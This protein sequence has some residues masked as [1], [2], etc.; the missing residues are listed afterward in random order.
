VSTTVERAFA[1]YGSHEV[2]RAWKE[3]PGL[4]GYLSTVNHKRLGMRYIY[5]AFVFFF[6]AGIM[7]LVMRTQ[8]AQ[9]NETLLTPQQYDELFTMH[10]TTMIFLFNTPVLAGFGIYLVPLMIGARDMAFPRLNAFGYYVFLLS[11]LF[12]YAGFLI[13]H[14]PDGG[15]FAYVPLTGPAYSPGYAID[16]WGLGIAFT[17]IST[18]TGAIN[19][20]VTIYKLRAPGMSLNRM[21]LFVWSMLVFSFMV[22]FSFP[23]I[24]LASSLLELDRIFGTQFFNPLAQGSVLLYQ[25]LFWFWGH[26]EVYILLIPA[27]GMVS[28]IIATF[29][30]RPIAG[31]LWIVH[32]LIAIGFISF[33]VW[34]HHMFATGIPILALSFFSA[35]SLLVVIPSGIQF[36]AWIAT[37][38]SGRVK[39]DTPLLFMLGFLLVFLAG[40]ITG[41]M[42]AILP[43]D[44]QVT[45]SY[46]VVAHFH[47]VLN[48]AVVFPIFGAIYYWAPKMTGRM[49][50]ERL[51]KWSF[52]T[53]F[54]SFN[55]AFFPMHI[56]GLL[57]MPRRVSTYLPGLGWDNLNLIET[58]GGFAF[59]IGAG[60][61]LF[62]FFWS[63]RHGAVA[64]PNPWDADSLEW[65]VP[66]PPPEYNFA[67]T[68]IVA[69][70]HPLWDE[71]PL[72]VSSSVDGDATRALAIEGAANRNMAETTVFDAQPEG[73]WPVPPD[74]YLPFF[75][76]FAL[77]IF[78]LGLLMRA[79]LVGWTGVA[80]AVFCLLRWMWR[81][82]EELR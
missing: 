26:P 28:M 65:S 67:T 17:G 23:S 40:G 1:E 78:F 49:L 13:G 12:M 42:V 62:N 69:S 74:T 2:E 35:V 55:V 19:F 8:L 57:G 31:Y 56:V 6:A 29:A 20:I 9:P 77:A 34:S 14:A 30:R 59:G 66:S 54:I 47:Y 4:A 51:G 37:L 79:Q 7:A 52:W 80:I 72:T 81:T 82:D 63:R 3:K 33:G 39:F 58:I 68:P 73:P 24:T 60:I 16:F 76:A 25:H 27:T 44:W 45:D 61:T 53:M 18:T 75:A 41:V 71:R 5:T 15:W 46:F 22:I 10:G 11:G 64:P 36:F 21:P 48:G 43:F 70:R 38:W 50:S 32:A